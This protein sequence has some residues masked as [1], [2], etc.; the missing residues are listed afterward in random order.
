MFSDTI[1]QASNFQAQRLSGVGNKKSLYRLVRK[2]FIYSCLLSKKVYFPA[3]SYFQSKITQDLTDEFALLFRH[4]NYP[5]LAYIAI[6]PSKEN[7]RGEALEKKDT[8]INTSIYDGYMDM[9]SRE[10]LVKRID[11]ITEP[12]FRAGKMVN[13]LSDYVKNET[14]LGGELHRLIFNYVGS[15]EHTKRI[16]EPLIVAVEKQEKAI[17]PEYIAMQDHDNNID[18][19]SERLMSLSLLK[20]YSSSTQQLY[21]A[22]SNNP[23]IRT[24]DADFLFPYEINFLDTCLFEELLELFPTIRDEVNKSRANEVNMLKHSER[25]KIFIDYYKAFIDELSLRSPSFAETTHMMRKENSDQLINYKTSLSEIVKNSSLARVLY[26]AV[27]GVIARTK[28]KLGGKLKSSRALFDSYEPY[29]FYALAHEIS[30]TFIKRY[31]ML[32]MSEMHEAFEKGKNTKITFEGG[33]N[34]SII[35]INSKVK[36]STITTKSED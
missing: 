32:L 5:K 3:A 26:R 11:S 20:A 21:E 24:Y 7:F 36:G 25:F 6:N 2:H 34:G 15:E 18:K 17:I 14:K 12:F 27:A 35:L 8:Y 23:L 16:F 4:G 13:S 28:L 31:E 30:E 29:F 9:V 1:F 22:Y 10:H 33:V 19:F